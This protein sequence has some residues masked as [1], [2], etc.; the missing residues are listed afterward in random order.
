MTFFYYFLHKILSFQSIIL[1]LNKLHAL[2]FF[3]QRPHIFYKFH[4]K[5]KHNNRALF[6]YILKGGVSY[7]HTHILFPCAFLAFLIG[8][9]SLIVRVANININMEM[10]LKRHCIQTGTNHIIKYVQIVQNRRFYCS[11]S[12]ISLQFD[13]DHVSA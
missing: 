7:S 11:L 6:P 3:Y 1:T 10:F 12:N 8:K 2:R 4:A 9:N 13:I 5:T